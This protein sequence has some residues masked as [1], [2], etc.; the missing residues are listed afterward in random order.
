MT[1]ISSQ[2]YFWGH[3]GVIL[4]HIGIAS[5]LISMYYV[6]EWSEETLRIIS[7]SLGWVLMAVN[8]LS[9]VPILKVRTARIEK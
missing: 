9:F 3:I 5:V 8:L 4:F 1:V 6:N 7:L 2:A